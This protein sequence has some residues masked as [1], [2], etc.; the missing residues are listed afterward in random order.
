MTRICV[1]TA[2]VSFPMSAKNLKNRALYH[3]RNQSVNEFS[4]RMERERNCEVDGTS[5]GGESSTDESGAARAPR[6][7]CR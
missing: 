1:I 2:G 7:S 6:T 4:V 5:F 3:F